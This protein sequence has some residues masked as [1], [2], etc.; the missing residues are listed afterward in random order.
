VRYLLAVE[1]EYSLKKRQNV[2]QNND[3]QFKSISRQAALPMNRLNAVTEARKPWST[4]YR[5]TS[6]DSEESG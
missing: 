5:F 6:E 3:K 1:A 2:K 4:S